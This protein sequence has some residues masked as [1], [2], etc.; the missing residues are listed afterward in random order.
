MKQY[1]LA[2]FMG[3][4]GLLAPLLI[5]TTVAAADDIIEAVTPQIMVGKSVRLEV[6]IVGSNG[7]PVTS[8]I[9]L[10]TSRLD[11]SPDN[12]AA[13]TASL[14]HTLS[15]TRGILSFD[16]DIPMAGHW[17]LTFTA[18][19]DGRDKPISG[20]VIFTA[21]EQGSANIHPSA[22]TERRILYYRNPMGLADTSQ[23]PRKDS[24]GMDYIAVYADEMSG[25]VGTVTL[26]PQKIQRTGVQ[27]AVVKRHRMVR[28]IKAAGMI[29][30]DESRMSVVTSR[31]SG[32]I[33]ELL[34]PATGADIQIGQPLLRVWVESSELLQKE[35]DFMVALHRGRAEEIATAMRNLRQLGISEVAIDMLRQ[36]GEPSRL[37]TLTAPTTGTVL[38]KPAFVG[39]RFSAGDPLYRLA[40]LSNVWVI[41]EVPERDLALVHLGQ[42]VEITVNAYPNTPFKGH[43][44]LIYADLNPMTRTVRVRIEMPNPQGLLKSGLYAEVAIE[45]EI[46]NEP[47]IAIPDSAVIDSGSRQVAFVAKD[48]GVFEPRALILGQRSDGLVEIRSGLMED[49]HIVVRGNFLIDAESNLRAALAAFTAPE[50]TP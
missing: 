19:V 47:V 33:E 11:M 31:F 5:F 18:M 27:T 3:A 14:H 32:F 44:A 2:L 13:M 37:L 6:R 16:A 46:G 26:T 50:V 12:M 41:A 30:L 20:Q 21:T 10:V 22:T 29:A 28:T 43:I 48:N 45:A 36:S 24:M 34:V 38:D 15:T 39:M 42:T 4:I 17:A 35:S 25:S 8:P 9:M 40:D 7:E 1:F 23:E 49:E